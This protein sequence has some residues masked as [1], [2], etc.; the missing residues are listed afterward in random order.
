MRTRA[1]TLIL[2]SLAARPVF[3][4]QPPNILKCTQLLAWLTGDVSSSRLSE[5]VRQRGIARVGAGNQLA[6]QE[7]GAKADLI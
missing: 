6:L 3:A 1:L 5:L 7:A 2:L 4:E